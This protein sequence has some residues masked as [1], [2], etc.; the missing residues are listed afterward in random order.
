MCVCVRACFF[1]CGGSARF[2]LAV[3]AGAWFCF[4]SA[5]PPPRKAQ[6]QKKRPRYSKQQTRP[7]TATK[8]ASPPPPPPPCGDITAKN[9]HPATR[10]SIYYVPTV[11]YICLNSV[12]ASQQSKVST[13]RFL[14]LSDAHI[15][16]V[17]PS[18]SARSLSAPACSFQVIPN[19]CWCLRGSGG[20]N[21]GTVI[22][23][24]KED[25]HRNPLPHSPL[26]KSENSDRAGSWPLY[27]GLSVFP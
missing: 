7:P 16:G 22:G 25:Y 14:P 20:G 19:T 1:G 2:L 13:V 21:I 15:N 23:G 24:L 17:L 18:S 5:S 26:S 9:H 6:H 12:T 8:T 4:C 27:Q 10:D 11:R 3:V